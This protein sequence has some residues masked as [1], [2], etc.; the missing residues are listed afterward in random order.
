MSAGHLD[1]VLIVYSSMEHWP[2]NRRNQRTQEA[3]TIVVSLICEIN[4]AMHLQEFWNLTASL[5][6]TVFTER[7][8]TLWFIRRTRSRMKRRPNWSI[9]CLA[10]TAPAHMLERQACRCS[11]E[12]QGTQERSGLFH[13]W[14]TD[15][16]L[17]GK[18][19][20]LLLLTSQPSQTMPWKRTMSL[21][22]TRPNWSTERHSDRPDG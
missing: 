12:D 10:R 21:T 22:G 15:P 17:Q 2:G 7:C 1:H 9:V 4:W 18:G 3:I 14:Y 5:Q 11:V 13:S 6:L 16:S 20:Q 19:E 8:G